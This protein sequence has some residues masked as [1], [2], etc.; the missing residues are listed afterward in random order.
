VQHP[1]HGAD[2]RPAGTLAGR[3][4]L[5][6]C[7]LDGAG[8]VRGAALRTPPR[9]MLRNDLLDAYAVLWTALRVARGPGHHRELGDGRRD[10][11]G[12][13]MRIVV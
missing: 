2:G 1:R 3:E 11:H 13:R 7:V 12:L 9:P 6:A 5:F 8:R 4:E 10:A